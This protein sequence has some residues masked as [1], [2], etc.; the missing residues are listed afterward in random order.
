LIQAGSGFRGYDQA[1]VGIAVAER[2]GLPFVYEVRGFLEA[3]WT[4][5]V[6]WG[7]RGDYYQRRRT[8]ER[9]CLDAAARVI[10]IAG[11]MRDE[12]VTRGIDAEK[13]TVVPN[14]VDVDRFAP[15]SKRPDLAETLG[16]SQ[17][18][19]IGY[20]SNLGRREGVERLIRAT[21]ALIDRGEDVACLVVG[22][23]PE[24]PNLITLAE[25]LG[26][27]GSVVLTG[28]VPN[29]EIEDYY[30][31]IDIFV[32]PRLPD[33]AARFVTPLKPLEAMAM[34]IPLVTSDL[35]ALRELAT[36][37]IRGSVFEPENPD[38]LTEVLESLLHNDGHRN[39]LSTAARKW[40]LAERTLESN[41]QRYRKAFDGIL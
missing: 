13:V 32:V 33:R 25:E 4:N 38:S 30:A 15:R 17:R 16:L 26:V 28:H 41:V 9:R 11:A 3:T 37:G 6:H 20:I 18:P 29:H 35:P 31:L 7:E 8:Q 19:V 39:R 40:V 27:S 24:R 1:L 36:P 2:A 5:D 10:T 21:R 23:G 34:G 12:I 22:D 14:A